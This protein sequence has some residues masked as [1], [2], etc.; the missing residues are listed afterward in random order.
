MAEIEPPS[1]Q[2]S[3]QDIELI[4]AQQARS[5]REASG[6]RGGLLLLLF[7]LAGVCGAGW[8]A[9]TRLK[10]SGPPAAAVAGAPE[11]P[12]RIDPNAPFTGIVGD[13]VPLG[14]YAVE[15]WQVGRKDVNQKGV[16]AVFIHGLVSNDSKRAIAVTEVE[17]RLVDA[18]GALHDPAQFH[19]LEQKVAKLNPGLGLER[20]WIFIVAEDREFPFV[21]FRLPKNDKALA[22]VDLN[23]HTPEIAMR[24]KLIEIEKRRKDLERLAQLDK[25]EAERVNRELAAEAAAEK[26]LAEAKATATKRAADQALTKRKQLEIRLADLEEEVARADAKVLDLQARVEEA[27]RADAKARKEQDA[28]ARKITDLQEKLAELKAQLKNQEAYVA[29]QRSRLAQTEG[30]AARSAEAM[31]SQAEHNRNLT[32]GKV[33]DAERDLRAASAGGDP[34][35]AYHEINTAGALEAQLERTAKEAL[36]L[37]RSRDR[38]R[39]ELKALAEPT[40]AEEP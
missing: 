23:R 6:G 16:D 27:K 5:E 2:Y 39:A 30:R 4:E 17:A 25:A 28:K 36:D 14:E 29:T 22:R 21:E 7:I 26:R 34:L 35:Y 40:Q 15:V 8:Y 33:A 18:G 9:W 37:L 3:I 31:L 19:W 10:D 11:R 12:A 32:A 1:R 24:W 13:A 38:T 20:G